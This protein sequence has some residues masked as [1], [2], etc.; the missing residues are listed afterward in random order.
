M[1]KIK[2]RNNIMRLLKFTPIFLLIITLGGC[3][4]KQ[5]K[6]QKSRLTVIAGNVKNLDVY[7]NTKEFT[8]DILDFRGK[9]TTFKDSI[10]SDGTFKIEFDLY[11]TQDL[12]VNPLVGKI[13]ASPGD[14]IHLEIDFKDIGNIQF[15]GDKQKSNTNLY[16]YLNSNYSVFE[17]R[18]R[19]TRKMNFNSYKSF[20]DSIKTIA[21]QKRQEF[22]TET[23][24]TSAII[25]WTK[26]YLNIRY[27]QSLLDF[28]FHYAYFRN[29]KSYQELDVP[30]NYYSFLDNNETYFSDSMIN[31]NIYELVN[32]Y[33]GDFAHR[34][35][36]DSTLTKENYY[37][38]LMEA[39]ID[40]LKNSY[41]KQMII[42]N[43]F[44]QNLNQND[45]D[46]YTA[47]K[48]ILENNVHELSL[49]IPLNY[50]YSELQ[51]QIKNPEINSNATLSKLNGTDGKSIIDSIWLQ[52]QG[53]VIYIDYW[54]TWCGPC[55]A[56]MPNSKKL[57]KKLAGENIEFVYIC[58]DSKEE[59]W[60][61]ALSQLQLDGQHYYTDKKQSGSIRNAFEINGIPHYMLVNKNGHIVESGSYLRP[62]NPETIKKIETLL[63]EE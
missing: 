30:D 41:F 27:Q 36:Y 3:V 22:I 50:Y 28:P 55:K 7:P 63:H 15:F 13:I 51:K 8:V 35:I 57:K 56:E 18:N 31:S 2:N 49:K 29:I 4:K 17:F 43:I 20:C 38:K 34:T 45:L 47:N 44:Y 19:E 58:M 9:K 12:E 26:D 60:K 24:A 1:R 37:S 10:K 14:S 23:N 33:T 25:N 53:K 59:Q 62:M 32:I 61:L 39:L 6:E 54:A 42:A 5:E 21:E 52:N 48:T 40:K 11:N 16:K 46:F